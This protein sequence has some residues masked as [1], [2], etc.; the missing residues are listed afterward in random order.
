MFIISGPTSASTSSL[1]PI[2]VLVPLWEFHERSEH[3]SMDA[4]TED[5]LGK[6]CF[7]SHLSNV[8]AVMVGINARLLV[9]LCHVFIVFRVDRA[10]LCYFLV[11]QSNAALVS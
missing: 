9:N 5:F 8:E 3:K 11:A 7:G 6:V 1:S 10:A 4:L 2:V